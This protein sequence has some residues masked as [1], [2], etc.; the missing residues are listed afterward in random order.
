[1]SRRAMV[2]LAVALLASAGGCSSKNDSSVNSGLAGSKVEQNASLRNSVDLI[3]IWLGH[4]ELDRKA[5]DRHIETLADSDER[6]KFDELAQSFETVSIAMEFRA[7]STM[8]IEIEILPPDSPAVRESTTGSWKI[9]SS[10]A[11][12]ITVQCT[13]DFEGGQ[14]EEQTMRYDIVDRDHIHTAAPVGEEL[15][16]FRP[17]F[18]FERREDA[19]VAEQP[20]E[21]QPLLR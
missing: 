2:W 9:V 5:L 6:A 4:A 12:S 16:P 19:Q 8:E 20:V 17:R 21:G 10:D 11:E 18:V 14:V 7:D 1:M 15:R 3:G 13:E